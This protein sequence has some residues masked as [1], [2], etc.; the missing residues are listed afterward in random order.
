MIKS[1]AQE[2]PTYSAEVAMLSSGQD[3]VTMK[4]LYTRVAAAE[5]P[6]TLT[7]EKCK[8]KPSPPLSVAMDASLAEVA[9]KLE[10][11][12]YVPVLVGEEV[13]GIVDVDGEVSML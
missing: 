3:M 2:D 7:L 1:A 9:I 4:N 12:S 6:K 13:C 5:D 11:Q 10:V 8:L